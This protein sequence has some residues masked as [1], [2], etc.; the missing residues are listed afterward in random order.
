MTA[1]GGRFKIYGRA[2]QNFARILAPIKYYCIEYGLP[3]LSALVIYTNDTVP[4]SGAE[5]DEMDIDR[6]FAYDWRSR[7]PLVPSEA[8][9]AEVMEKHKEAR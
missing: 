3:L 9:F 7:R 4:G 5:A 2:L 8:E 6:V 1:S